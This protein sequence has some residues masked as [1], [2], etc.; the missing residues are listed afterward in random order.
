MKK[1]LITIFCIFLGIM[2]V[3]ASSKFSIDTSKINLKESKTENIVDKF[4]DKYAISYTKNN[5]DEKLNEKIIDL[6]K[7]VTYLLLG[8]PNNIDES[9]DNYIKRHKDYLSLRYNP[10][11]PKDESTLTG[12]DENSEEYKDDILSGISVP[13][14]FLALDKLNIIYKNIDN[15]KVT[16]SSSNLIVC[17]VVLPNISLKEPDEKDSMKFKTINTNLTM[18]YYFKELNGE[19]K[20]YYLFG[21]TS[22]E[23]DDYFNELEDSESNNNLTHS[24]SY[25]SEISSIYNTNKLDTLSTDEIKNIYNKNINKTFIINTYYNNAIIDTASGFIISKGLLVTTWNYLESSLINGQYIVAK[26]NLGNI[27]EIDGI[28]TVNPSAN[29]AV[30]KLKDY[31]GDKVI[32]GDSSKMI[33]EDPVFTINSKNG[34]GLTGQS[35]IITANSDYIQTSIPLSETDEG[36]PLINKY[37]EVIGINTSLSI[38]FSIS[39]AIATNFLKEFEMKFNNIDFNEIEHMDFSDLKEQYYYSKEGN[40]KVIKNISDKKWKTYSKIGNVEETIKLKLIKA[41]YKDG[42]VSLRYNNNISKFISS[43][44]L[45]SSF[46]SELLKQGYKEIVNS[47]KKTIYESNDYKAIIMDEFNYLIIVMV[48]L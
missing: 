6:S 39:Y 3:Y 36:S 37:G 48:R 15:I 8:E 32:L 19:Y 34:Y 45:S 4:N 47:D 18:Y 30:L 26:D 22:D 13:G 24:F 46:K 29:I 14:M 41:S 5:I 28:V 9:S 44:E 17:S 23:L 35:G 1:I 21:E 20:L 11:I 10:K 38:N 12:F 43:M 31:F 42:I 33:T 7:K 27:H 40:E 25:N 2:T 16:Q